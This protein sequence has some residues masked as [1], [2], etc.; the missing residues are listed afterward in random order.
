M[1]GWKLE[2]GKMS[3]YVA[4][5]ILCFYLFNKPEYFSEQIAKDKQVGVQHR[6]SILSYFSYRKYSFFKVKTLNSNVHGG[7]NR[8][9][10]KTH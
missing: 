3:L 4:M 1:G 5:P 9:F 8:W 6:Q 2:V 10:L 7:L